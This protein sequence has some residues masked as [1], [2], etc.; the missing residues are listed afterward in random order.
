MG[1]FVAHYNGVSEGHWGNEHFEAS[2][3]SE[4]L[5][6]AREVERDF[7]ELTLVVLSPTS[8]HYPIWRADRVTHEHDGWNEDGIALFPNIFPGE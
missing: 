1:D 2:T 4:L 7:P 6:K 8:M 5:E 3:R